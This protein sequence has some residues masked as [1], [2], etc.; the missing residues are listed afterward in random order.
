MKTTK[1][2]PYN[3]ILIFTGYPL[4]IYS[5]LFCYYKTHTLQSV[6]W[7]YISGVKHKCLE[8]LVILFYR[9]WTLLVFSLWQFFSSPA[10]LSCA[11]TAFSLVEYVP[12]LIGFCHCPI[13]I[14]FF[15]WEA[16]FLF[17]FSQRKP[18]F[19]NMYLFSQ[20]WHI[21]PVW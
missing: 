5:L 3:R 14:Y 10:S 12:L 20:N 7:M 19:F 13:I 21:R 1:Q 18:F 17:Y 8:N 16:I 11:T 4:V 2:Y 6:V 15:Y 9:S